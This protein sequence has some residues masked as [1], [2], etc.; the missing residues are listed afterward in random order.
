MED[1]G[2]KVVTFAETLPGI[3]VL[4]SRIEKRKRLNAVVM[5]IAIAISIILLIIFCF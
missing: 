1:T 4:L 2:A 3:N 5:A